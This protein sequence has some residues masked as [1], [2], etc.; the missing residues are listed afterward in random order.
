M[1]IKLVG[2]MVCLARRATDSC[3]KPGGVGAISAQNEFYFLADANEGNVEPARRRVCIRF[4]GAK[5]V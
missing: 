5:R 4:S 3:F 1:Y 2:C